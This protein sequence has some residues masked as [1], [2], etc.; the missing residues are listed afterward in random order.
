MEPSLP[1]SKSSI[2]ALHSVR[3]VPGHLVFPILC[4]RIIVGTFTYGTSLLLERNYVVRRYR[5]QQRIAV[6]HVALCPRISDDM[7]VLPQRAVA[8]RSTGASF[9]QIAR[10]TGARKFCAQMVQQIR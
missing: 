5:D 7:R 4:M 3:K 8:L 1:T 10:E 9:R 2:S 6:S